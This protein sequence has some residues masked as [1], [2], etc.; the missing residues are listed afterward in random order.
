MEGGA[1]WGEGGRQGEGVGGRGDNKGQG[2]Q[3]GRTCE[4]DAE[5]TWGGGQGRQEGSVRVT[6]GMVQGRQWAVRVTR[7]G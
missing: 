7:E 2:R 3:E 1:D 6:R 5:K 4:R